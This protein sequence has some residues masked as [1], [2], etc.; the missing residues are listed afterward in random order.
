MRVNDLNLTGT[1]AAPSGATQ[2]AKQTARGSSAAAGLTNSGSSGDRI[3]FSNTLTSLSSA[4]SSYGTDRAAKVQAL[5]A[6]Y[7]SGNYRPDSLATSRGMVSEALG[8]GD[9]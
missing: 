4:M 5:A 3:E 7:R 9:K 1:S 8:A 2:E 6:Q